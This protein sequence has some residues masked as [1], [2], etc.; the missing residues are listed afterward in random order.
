MDIMGRFSNPQ[1]LEGWA[2]LAVPPTQRRS[3]DRSAPRQ[4]TRRQ[5]GAVKRLVIRVLEQDP[6]PLLPGQIANLIEATTG[7]H[8]ARSSIK[9]A[10]RTGSQRNNGPFVR[11]SDGY[12]L[13]D[14]MT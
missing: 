11:D 7:E 5:Y 12:R 4:P 10:L 14:G 3:A 13:R 8:V 9:N 6:R 1:V 2:R